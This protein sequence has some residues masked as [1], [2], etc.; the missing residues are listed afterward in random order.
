M[1]TS[2][3]PPP[4][5]SILSATERRRTGLAVRLALAAATDASAG[6]GIAPGRCRSI[7][8]TSNGDGAIVHAILEAPRPCP[9]GL[10]DPVPQFGPQR[11]GRLLVDRHRIAGFRELPRLPRRDFG[12]ALL[13]AAAEVVVEAAPVLLCV[14]E[15]PCPS[16]SIGC[17]RPIAPSPAPWCLRRSLAIVGSVRLR[18]RYHAAPATPERADPRAP[19]LQALALGNAAARGLRLLESIAATEPDRIEPRCWKGGWRLMSSHARPHLHPSLI[20]HGGAMSLLD[21]VAS[22]TGDAI[23]CRTRSHLAPD[24]PLRRS[25]RLACICG[26]EY[27]PTSGGAAW[28]SC[29]GRGAQPAGYVASLRAVELGAARLDDPA[30]GTLLVSASLDRAETAGLIYQFFLG[31]TDGRRL[32][33]GRATI[34]LPRVLA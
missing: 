32:M 19:G 31:A 22:W 7:F 18:V 17:D 9:P 29:R 21:E 6:A 28:G 3:T 26:V 12:A 11:R 8:A 1:P 4:A 24:N 5:P 15:R 23:Q 34:I 33:S 10:A 25:G 27:R 20:P 30:A 13:A 2:L 16:P 14:Y